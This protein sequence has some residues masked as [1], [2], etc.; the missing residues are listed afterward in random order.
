MIHQVG[1]DHVLESIEKT[2][3]MATMCISLTTFILCTE[4]M[5][6]VSSTHHTFQGTS[7]DGCDKWR[8]K[9]CFCPT[10][11]AI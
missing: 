9:E 2:L 10:L 4:G 11:T 7:D 5:D 1:M 8:F 3:Q 6:T